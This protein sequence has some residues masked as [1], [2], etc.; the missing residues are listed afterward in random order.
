MHDGPEDVLVDAYT[1]EEFWEDL[2]KVTAD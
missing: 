1:E 2:L